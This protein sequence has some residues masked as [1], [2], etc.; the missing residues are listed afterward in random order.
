MTDF[1][2]R[3][4]RAIEDPCFR[5]ADFPG[6]IAEGHKLGDDLRSMVEQ[7]VRDS[8]DFA[9]GEE[10]REEAAVVVDRGR[11][12]IATVAAA[13]AALETKLA[14]RRADEKGARIEAERK[15]AIT[16]RDELAERFRVI[17]P[18]AVAALTELFGLVEANAQRL[19]KAGVKSPDAEATARGLKSFYAA[20]GPVDRFATMKIPNWKGKGRA[21]PLQKTRIDVHAGSIRA[22]RQMAAHRETEREAIWGEYRVHPVE[23]ESISF[24]VR[25][26]GGARSEKG[27][28][29][30]AEPWQG[31]MTHAEAARLRGH[32]VTV[33]AI[34]R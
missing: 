27:E 7:A 1:T 17:V 14:A 28:M 24:K 32:D 34:D 11:R 31:E 20:G 8:I 18:Q 25:D 3:A 29:V 26:K 12:Q 5:V 13:V 22:A 9:L 6:L 23:G 15:A 19:A 10:D 30:F 4:A 16:E 33:E 21:W 2:D